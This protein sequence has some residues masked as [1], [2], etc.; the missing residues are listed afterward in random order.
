MYICKCFCYFIIITFC[1]CLQD[2]CIQ[3]VVF[4]DVRLYED[5]LLN[6]TT[7]YDAVLHFI[8][9]Q[10]IIMC[11]T[12]LHFM[13]LHCI[14]CYIVKAVIQWSPNDFLVLADPNKHMT[15]GPKPTEYRFLNVVTTYGFIQ[16]VGYC[17]QAQF[18]ARFTRYTFPQNEIWL[19]QI[20]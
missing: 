13:M 7:I 2:G 4:H 9:L 20:Q 19:D 14:W 10:W 1:T 17:L 12:I 15:H 3:N 16:P 6:D 18:T 11:K 5:A 8:M